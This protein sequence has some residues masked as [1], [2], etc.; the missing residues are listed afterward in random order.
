MVFFDDLIAILLRLEQAIFD[1]ILL[2]ISYG[3]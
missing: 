3:M 2:A 1:T